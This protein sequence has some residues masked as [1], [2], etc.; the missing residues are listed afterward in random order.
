MT[1]QGEVNKGRHD[2]YFLNA[3]NTGDLQKKM[4]ILETVLPESCKA[5]CEKHMPH[6][7]CYP[8]KSP[9]RKLRRYWNNATKYLTKTRGKSTAY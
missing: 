7:G 1:Y 5:I 8:K 6:I 4:A 3:G 9:T 2:Q